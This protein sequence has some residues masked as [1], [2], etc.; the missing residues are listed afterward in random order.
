M[1]ASPE[2]GHRKYDALPTITLRAV[3]LYI[4]IVGQCMRH[5]LRRLLLHVSNTTS[6]YSMFE[7]IT[8]LMHLCADI[9]ALVCVGQIKQEASHREKAY[10]LASFY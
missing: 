6:Y 3:D 5:E 10:W 2:F 7:I 9:L 4:Q 1:P 8:Y